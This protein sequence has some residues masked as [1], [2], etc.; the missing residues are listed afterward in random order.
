MTKWVKVLGAMMLACVPLAGCGSTPQSSGATGGASGFIVPAAT[1]GTTNNVDSP[2]TTVHQLA[3]RE[4]TEDN[5][6]V[7]TNA[8]FSS[9]FV[10]VGGSMYVTWPY[11]TSS[12]SSTDLDEIRLSPYGKRTVYTGAG[13]GASV[14]ASG[15]HV[16]FTARPWDMIY[17]A[18]DRSTYKVLGFDPATQKTN[19][20]VDGH[21]LVV[22]GSSAGLIVGSAEY[23][24]VTFYPTSGAGP[25]SLCSPNGYDA[26]VAN[27][28]AALVQSYRGMMLCGFDGAGAEQFLPYP[29]YNGVS[30]RSIAIDD[31]YAY[32]VHQDG[33]AADGLYRLDLSTKAATR[34]ATGSTYELVHTTGSELWLTDASGGIYRMPSDGSSAPT[35]VT[36]QKNVIQL[37]VHD[38]YVYFT[39]DTSD[40]IACIK[41]M[42]KP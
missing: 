22:A 39:R 9:R 11:A 31:N 35:L 8:Y 10:F 12:D 16:Y 21:A 41:R 14:A 6:E 36:N 5:Y 25:V 1:G 17:L 3:P 32:L 24:E 4:C 38:S 29:E 42:P 7:L 15:G 13:Y 19:V 40:A 37:E 18:E 34:I 2:W 30:V 26:I 27:S 28:T 20:A 33:S 23:G